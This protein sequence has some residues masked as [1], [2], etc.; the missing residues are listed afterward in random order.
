MASRYHPISSGLWSDPRLDGLPFEAKAFFAFLCSNERVRP[1]G[2]YLV[3][4]PQL[5]VDAGVPPRTVRRYVEELDRRGLI[6][7][8][9]AW[10]FVRKYFKRQ[11]KQRRLLH[12]VQADLSDCDSRS[13]LEDFGSIY[14]MLRKWSRT[15]LASLSN[16]SRTHVTTLAV[17]SSYRATTEQLQSKERRGPGRGGTELLSKPLR[18]SDARAALSGFDQFQAAYPRREKWPDAERA[19]RQVDARHHVAAILA[20]IARRLE[21]G[22]WEPGSPDRRRFIP[23]PGSYLRGRRWEDELGPAAGAAPAGADE[24]PY[25]GWP[26]LWDC[27]CGEI[28]EGV[29]GQP[30]PICP[31][32]GRPVGP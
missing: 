29:R 19:W 17:Q 3:T 24:D 4:D 8:D 23:L 6:R 7:R 22:T 16:P 28:H 32:T 30:R 26:H 31:R 13:I 21:T 18:G 10:L 15:R 25:A 14:P 2:I 27:A 5:A 1:S 20:D 12:G 11:P 9:G